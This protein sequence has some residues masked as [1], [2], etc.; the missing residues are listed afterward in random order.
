VAV[1]GR[2]VALVYF[3]TERRAMCTCV[4]AGLVGV[5]VEDLVAKPPGVGI[6]VDDEWGVAM[7]VPVG[8]LLFSALAAF[9]AQFGPQV[10][11]EHARR[12]IFLD[13]ACIH[14]TD[15]ALKAKGIQSLGGYLAASRAMILL[16]DETYFTRLW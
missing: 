6:R 5:L 13:C 9:W 15:D 10:A 8:V 11:G 4:L 3:F 14:Q 1:V 16:W 7:E 2:Y 12:K